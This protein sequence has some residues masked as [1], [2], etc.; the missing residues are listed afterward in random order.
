LLKILAAYDGNCSVILLA[1]SE[2]P[3]K[4]LSEL[5]SDIQATAIISDRPEIDGAIRP[6]AAIEV[7]TDDLRGNLAESEQ[8]G[9]LMTTSGTTG[10]PKIVKHTL[11]SLARTVR[12]TRPDKA[13]PVWGLTYEAT[14]FAG[15]QVVLQAVFGGGTLVASPAAVPL[16]R[17]VAEF[18][19]M[20][21]THVS[22]TPTF[23]RHV[24]MDPASAT[25]PLRQITIGGEIADQA[26]LHTLGAKFPE[27]Y[28]SHIYASTEVGVGFSV[29]DG[30]E[31]FP[32]AWLSD[33]PGELKLK[34][35]DGRLWIH[36]SGPP[37]EYFGPERIGRDAEGFVDT[38]DRV[39]VNNDRVRFLGRDT[40]AVNV[41]GSK[42]YP[43]LVESILNACPLVSL[44][45]VYARKNPFTGSLLVADIVPA[46]W[47]SDPNELKTRLIK[48]CREILPQEAVPAV[49]KLV[50]RLELNASGKLHRAK[51]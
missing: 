13:A 28:I 41:G 9:W 15:L 27:A 39:V 7:T 21:V 3:A 38:Q 46:E 11:E 4:D 49:M 8:T 43:E 33:P 40:G 31:G 22:A 1:S 37:G 19:S 45:H 32:A 16:A 14:R 48:Y 29:H 10:K 5:A 51:A 12:K 6:G 42:V 47:P 44:S 50:D 35:V 25:L 20:G 17:R 24:L 23:W 2:L 34:I 36:T 26:L 30:Q 18:A